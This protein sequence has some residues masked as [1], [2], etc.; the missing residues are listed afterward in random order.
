MRADSGRVATVALLIAA[1]L[2]TGCISI[3]IFD[4]SRGPLVETSLSGDEHAPK[5]LLV[6]LSGPLSM[7]PVDGPWLAPA[8]E[9]SVT[10]LHEELDFARENGDIKAIVLRIDSP[11]GT[12]T[13]SD[14]M[15]REILRFKQDTGIPIVAQLMGVAASGGYYVAMA[16]DEVRA[17]PTTVTGSIGVIFVGVSVAGLMEKLGIYDQTITSG[18]Q[19]SVGSP[20]KRMTKAE[21]KQLQALVDDFHSV[22][23]EVVDNGRPD[24]D[25][26]RIR[27]LADGRIYSAQQ[28]LSEGLVD[29]IS[30]LEDSLTRAQSLA[31][32]EERQVVTYNRNREWKQNIYSEAP[33]T[34]TLRLDLS[35]LFGFDPPPPGF[36]YIWWPALN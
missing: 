36:Y 6:D 22:F 9:G 13:A 2:P 19:K 3:K 11:G 27:Q 4:I 31:G 8:R 23:V 14:I 5:V 10:R 21:R 12:T 18:P 29:A 26:E 1:L 7:D 34:P 15:Y 35:S 30:S 20:L 33:P 24:L 25:A 16:A 28:A 17:L 32:I